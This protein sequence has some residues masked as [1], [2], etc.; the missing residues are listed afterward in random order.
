MVLARDVGASSEEQIRHGLKGDVASTPSRPTDVEK[1]GRRLPPTLG[2]SV[3][4]TPDQSP[5][6]LNLL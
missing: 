4:T 1:K 3:P 2:Q 6:Q 5:A